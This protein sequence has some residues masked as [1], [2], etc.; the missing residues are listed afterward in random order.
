VIGAYDWC[1]LPCLVYLAG[2]PGLAVMTSTDGL[3]KSWRV[4]PA[5]Y[6]YAIL[7]AAAELSNS[8]RTHSLQGCT[9]CFASL[10]WNTY[11]QFLLL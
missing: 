3:I 7:A 9:N 4:R 8:L 1:V 5:T 6:Q 10:A 2:V 11:M